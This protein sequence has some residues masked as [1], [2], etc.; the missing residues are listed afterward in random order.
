MFTTQSNTKPGPFN[1]IAAVSLAG[2]EGR[3]VKLATSG[4]VLQATP[5]TALTDLALYVLVDLLTGGGAAGSQV[6]VRPLAPDEQIRIVAKG[7]GSA[8]ATLVNADPTASSGV[9]AGKLR[10]VPATPGIYVQGG[11]AEEDFVDGQLV[12]VRPHP[13]VA[14]VQSADSLTALTFTTPTAA[15]V[16]ALRNAVSAILVA[17]GL[18]V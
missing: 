8:G 15:E 1:V 18:M 7:T 13:A 12:L 4:G 14:R 5:L 17:Q 9:D 2:L 11:F 10:A 3:I 16:Q 6:T